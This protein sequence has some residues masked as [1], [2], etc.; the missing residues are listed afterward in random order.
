M[1][2]FTFWLQQILYSSSWKGRWKERKAAEYTWPVTFGTK[3][4]YPLE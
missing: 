3:E 2:V 4:T 1:Y